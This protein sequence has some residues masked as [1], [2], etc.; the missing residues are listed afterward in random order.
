VKKAGV[1]VLA[2][3]SM[4]AC[5]SAQ[6]KADKNSKDFS[7][8]GSIAYGFGLGGQWI[9]A[10]VT[11][12][13]SAIQ[14]RSDKYLN[15]G[16]G[17]KL[18][19]GGVYRLLENLDAQG[20]LMY[21]FGTPE[22]EATDQDAQSGDKVTNTYKTGTFGI[23]ILAVPKVKVF[24]LLDMYV[25][26]GMG[27]YFASLSWSNSETP[28]YDGNYT[29]SPAIGFCGSIGVN[30]PVYND[31]IVYAEMAVEE[32]SFTVTSILSANDGSLTTFEQDSKASSGVFPPAKIPGSNVAF[33]I[34]AKFPVF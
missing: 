1:F 4:A 8:C 18:E 10:S 15:Y 25:G 29:T 3:L 31:L 7:L 12:Y 2:V 6:D 27:L 11:H 20:V 21:N 33:R 14:E 24:D 32:M 9:D 28:Q 26:F 22:I 17:F 19:L 16:D 34:G 23:K 5:L 30:Y 13:G